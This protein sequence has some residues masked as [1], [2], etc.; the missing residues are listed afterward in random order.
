[1]SA[2][3]SHQVVE[4]SMSFW[5]S[6]FGERQDSQPHESTFSW[7]ALLEWPRRSQLSNAER[8]MS[9]RDT[10]NVNGRWNVN[11]D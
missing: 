3:C 4:K 6:G 1:M 2:D 10:P 8:M 7:T 5:R 11:C 9:N